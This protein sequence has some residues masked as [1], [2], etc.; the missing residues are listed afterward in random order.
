MTGSEVTRIRE[1]IANEYKAA[2]W[3][4][5]GLAYGAS[6]HDFIS[7]RLEN[8]G[9]SQIELAF[10]VGEQQAGAF[11]ADTL[12]NLPDKPERSA[13][14][15]L[16][17]HLRGKT[18]ETTHL[19]DHIQEMWETIDLLKREF[20]EEGAHKIIHAPGITPSDIAVS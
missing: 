6:R 9:R 20:G 19:R 18:E 3:G 10:L 8:M 14:L 4:L 1:N 7:A 16:L 11:V 5:T 17:P 2:M 15:D 13:I 12:A